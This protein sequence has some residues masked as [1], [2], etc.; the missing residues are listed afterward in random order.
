V[1]GTYLHLSL[2]AS[3]GQQAHAYSHSPSLAESKRPIAPTSPVTR[4]EGQGGAGG[5]VDGVPDVSAAQQ[6]VAV[7]HGLEGAGESGVAATVEDVVRGDGVAGVGAVEGVAG[8]AGPLVGLHEDLGAVAGVDA[9]VDVEEEG[10]VDVPRAE[11]DGWCARVDVVPVAGGFSLVSFLLLLLL[12]LFFFFFR[13]Q[14]RGS[15]IDG[16]G[17]DGKKLT[18]CSR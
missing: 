8:G 6:S 18:C 13:G 1:T 2:S 17:D 14:C 10:V 9:V 4:L 16:A 12:L 7:W 5:A 3:T 11:A 15:R